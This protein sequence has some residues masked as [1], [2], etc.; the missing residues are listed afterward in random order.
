M[1][2]ERIDTIY[3]A[4]MTKS[5]EEIKEKAPLQPIE[6]YA[7]VSDSPLDQLQDWSTAGMK[8]LSEN[9]VAV[10]ILAG[11][12]GT[13]LGFD[14]PKGA[15]DIGMPSNSSLFQYF[16]ERMLK[17]Q[18]LVEKEC[19]VVNVVLPI[20]VMTSRMNHETTTEFFQQHKYF[21][22]EPSQ[23][24]F[25]TQG[26][27][28]CLTQDGKII[29]ETPCRVARASDGNGG[30]YKA[31]EASGTLDELDAAAVQYVHVF[32]VDNALCRPADPVF[33]GYCLEKQAECGNKVVWKVS[34]DEKVGI[35]A[36]RDG[37]YCVV[38]Y[39]ELDGET[40]AMM[41]SE[42]DKLVYGAGNICNHLFSVDFLKKITTSGELE[43]HVAHK[44]IP[45][46]DD[47]GETVHP[48]SNSGI[49]LEAFIFDVFPLAESMAVLDVRRE[50]EFSPVKNAPGNSIDSPDSARRML[51]GQYRRWIEMAGGDFTS[52]LITSGPVSKYAR[53]GIRKWNPRFL[54]FD[55]YTNGF[56]YYKSQASFE[57]NESPRASGTILSVDDKTEGEIYEFQCS[58]ASGKPFRCRVA[59]QKELDKWLA[60]LKD[61]QEA[62]E[63]LCEVSPLVSYGGEGLQDIQHKKLSLP[64]HLTSTVQRRV[65]GLNSSGSIIISSESMKSAWCSAT[66]DLKI[67][68]EFSVPTLNDPNDILIETAFATINPV[69]LDTMKPQNDVILG[70][71]FSG[72]VSAVGADVKDFQVGDA[73]FGCKYTGCFAQMIKTSST[74]VCK[75]PSGLSLAEAALLPYSGTIAY[76]TV[77]NTIQP[78]DSVLIIADKGGIAFLACQMIKATAVCVLAP[79]TYYSGLQVPV[80]SSESAIPFKPTAVID[81][82]RSSELNFPEARVIPVANKHCTSSK[83]T[84]TELS[85]MMEDRTL[86]LP[87]HS[88]IS[89]D[90]I[91]SA[92][93]T[94]RNGTQSTRFVVRIRPSSIPDQIVSKINA[95]GQSHI[96]EFYEKGKLTPT[97][98][99][100]FT[101][102]LESIDLPRAMSLFEKSMEQTA[103][104]VGDIEP[105][106]HV[107]LIET[108]SADDLESWT[109]TGLNAIEQGQVGVIILAGGQ[110]TRLGFSGPK[111][112]YDIGLPSGKT[113]FQLFAERI[114]KLESK[115]SSV[116]P[117]YV[118]TSQMNDA[119]TR[120]YFKSQNHFGLQTPITC[121]PQ[122]VLPCFTPQGKLMLESSH[123]LAMASDGNGGIYAA[124][125]SSGA[126]DDMIQRKIQYVHVFSVDNAI[127]KAADPVFLGY[128]ISRGADCGNKVLWKASPVEKVGVLAKRNKQ[129]CVIEYSEL[130]ET[131]RDKID[132]RTNQLMFGAANICNHFFTLPFLQ[133]CVSTEME[134][135]VA[136]KKIPIASAD[137][138]TMSVNENNGIKLEAFIFDVFY[139]S[140][141]MAV[142]SVSR[143]EEFSPVK[144]AP[145]VGLSDSPETAC[146][147]LSIQA[148]NWLSKAGVTVIPGDAMV[149]ITPLCSYSGENLGSYRSID[150]SQSTPVLLSSPDDRANRNVVPSELREELEAFGQ[151]HVLEFIDKQMIS[152]SEALD[153][154][155]Q[156]KTLS[157]GQIQQHFTAAT[158]EPAAKPTGSS[159]EPLDAVASSS[160]ESATEWWNIGLKAIEEQKVGVV[161]LSGPKGMC[162]IG[163]PSHASRFELFAHRIRRLEQLSKS[164]I[165]PWYVMTSPMNHQ[166]T[167]DYFKSNDYFGLKEQQ[168]F[169]FPQGTLP[170]LTIDGKLIL[171]SGSTLARAS[172]GHGGLYQAIETSGALKDMEK[173]GIEYLHVFEVDNAMCKVADPVFL[174][175]C[176]SEKADCGSKVV[177]KTDPEEQLD[178]FGKRNGTTCVIEYSD[179]STLKYL[180]TTD[181]TL[182]YGAGNICNHFYTLAFLKQVILPKAKTLPY[183]ATT[184]EK[185]MKLESFVYDV[186]EFSMNPMA[187]LAVDRQEEFSKDTACEMISKQAERW[188]EANGGQ[189]QG[190]GMCEIDPLVSYRGEDLKPLVNSKQIQRPAHLTPSTAPF[191]LPM[192]T[193][194]DPESD[195]C[196]GG[197]TIG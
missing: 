136:K 148:R 118:M 149:E 68:S 157:L 111:G 41:D 123:K 178:V 52:H 56:R 74:A 130:D 80:V 77:S 119:E 132:P 192:S 129:Y 31:L 18:R 81:F 189:L 185:G 100:S 156:L 9:K 84:L 35:L 83:E 154:L 57:E 133:E 113:L 38:E 96:L 159:F 67:G 98:V 85:R 102:A 42:N 79:K 22:L 54:V 63:R 19:G 194:H 140:K 17:L 23:V 5:S 62:T 146:K 7:S 114:R 165:L 94:L 184:Y 134:Y 70:S 53:Q 183:H 104:P 101:K 82:S 89:M 131:T 49:K 26:T 135:H 10:L 47:E 142:L 28:P 196:L 69:D 64:F 30:I 128:C 99:D 24:H 72:N 158:K 16:C 46:V 160:S 32:S 125:Q 90:E 193:D 186:F 59:T 139:R 29:M 8:L 163:L 40:A 55:A 34:P 115:T 144:N 105:I 33:I 116:I 93:C 75:I 43:F 27:L 180:K 117:L 11:G 107:D 25:F 151:S 76:E 150:C 20:Y 195:K 177:W 110:G 164:S 120:D 91:A 166:E 174:G 145:G 103:H 3:N 1:D 112:M 126:M 44:K 173:R 169:F 39:S 182:V 147:M 12:Q 21:G 170:C 176:I 187:I 191:P 14:G 124:L 179:E 122:G 106:E 58:T 78:D 15:Y 137:G 51:S 4:A 86:H 143:D 45:H 36:K 190:T 60:A 155:S 61:A 121:F 87:S 168:V 97:Q 188:I 71:E 197:C 92:M 152:I 162:D 95:L 138:Y 171:E 37:Q 167:V 172:D 109:T 73:V 66:G 181:D 65:S 141:N 13:R 127:C 88:D 108:S 175:Y 6:Q 2:L 153:L 48:T 161:V 50:D